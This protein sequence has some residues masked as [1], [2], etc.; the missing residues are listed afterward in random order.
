MSEHDCIVLRGSI[1]SMPTCMI[2]I[3]S[4]G[5]HPSILNSGIKWLFDIAPGEV[6]YLYAPTVS[7]IKDLSAGT[8]MAGPGQSALSILLKK[9]VI[10]SD[11]IGVGLFYE[12]RG[13]LQGNL[14][15][16]GFAGKI[17]LLSCN[18]DHSRI[19]MS[20]YPNAYFCLAPVMREEAQAW[21]RKYCA[22]VLL[23][24]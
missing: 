16:P 12:N 8:F 21:R 14:P 6:S 1:T 11:D 2:D 9:K 24:V 19:V 20:T 15:P 4:D 3:S 10:H 22:H 18:I 23:T 7:M 13:D 17:L 5:N